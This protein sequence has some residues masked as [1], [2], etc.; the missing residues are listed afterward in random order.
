M[1]ISYFISVSKAYQGLSICGSFRNIQRESKAETSSEIL[2]KINDN[3]LGLSKAEL[4]QARN[5]LEVLIL[6]FFE[7]SAYHLKVTLSAFGLA[8]EVLIG[9]AS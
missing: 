9:L 6:H 5:C 3:K 2:E 8:S 4:S 7:L 1:E